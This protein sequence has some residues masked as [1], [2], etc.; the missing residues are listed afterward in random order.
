M[1][2]YNYVLVNVLYYFKCIRGRLLVKGVYEGIF[3]FV[4][5]RFFLR[6]VNN[7]LF[8]FFW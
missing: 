2:W 7:Y 5:C 3:I 8:I 6:K 4:K 1:F